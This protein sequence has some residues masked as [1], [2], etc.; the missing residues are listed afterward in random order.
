VEDFHRSQNLLSVE[1][2][3]RGYGIVSKLYPYI[4]SLT[5]WRSWEYA[6]YQRYTLDEPALDIGCGDG[7]FF[8]LVWP[9]ARDVIGIDLDSSTAEVARA[10]GIYREVKIGPAHELPLKPNYF[11]S[12]F[13]NCSLEHMDHLPEVFQNISQCLRPGGMFLLSVV[14]DK[15]LQWSTLPL[16]S[17]VMGQ[18]ERAASLSSGYMTYHHMVNLFSPEAWAEQM[19]DVDLLP[20]DYIPIVPEITA[21]LFLLLDQVWHLPAKGGEVGDILEKELV[22]WKSFDSGFEQI[23]RAFLH[24]E[25]DWKN[26]GGAV[27]CVRKK[28]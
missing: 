2:I 27:F 13:A 28:G 14:T 22:T 4:P 18:P 24:M 23:F 21:R 3:L 26:C 7:R 1:E 9:S 20:Q 15:L 19:V 10:S 5:L 8:R 16:L 12:V 11:A 6:A 25:K 17:E